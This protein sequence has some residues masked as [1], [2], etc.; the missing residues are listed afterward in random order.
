MLGHGWNDTPASRNRVCGRGRRGTRADRWNGGHG[1]GRRRRPFGLGASRRREAR[2]RLRQA[3]P[4]GADARRR[5]RLRLCLRPCRGRQRASRRG[6][7]RAATGHR[8]PAGQRPGARRDRA[9]LCPCRRHRHRQGDLRHRDR[10]PQCPRSRAP[11]AQP[12]R[13]R[14]RPRAPRRRRR[15]QRLHRRRGRLRQQHQRRYRPD[16]A[17][18]T[19]VRLPLVPRRSPVRRRGCTT[20]RPSCRQDCRRAPACRARPSSTR[21]CSARRATISAGRRSVRTR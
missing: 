7:S 3:R 10:R 16:V 9:G 21:P 14:L 8:P 17:D 1:G 13:P 12:P 15:T 18:A 4:A 19:S 20:A 2:H 11:A 6:D 5:S